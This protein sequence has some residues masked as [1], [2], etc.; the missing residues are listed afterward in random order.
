MLIV[1][2]PEIS[3]VGEAFAEFG[4]LRLLPGRQ[5]DKS[6]VLDAD[7]LLVRSVTPIDQ[8]LLEG[9]RVR[10]VGTATSGV[11]H[12]DLEYLASRGTAF[13]SAP[14]CN[15][16]A[17]ADYVTSAVLAWSQERG[18]SLKGL[19]AGVIGC[20]RIGSRVIRRLGALG[21]E[22]IENDPPLQEQS[23]ASRYRA[24][25]ETLKADIV[26]L[27]VPLTCGARHPT[28][29]LLRA[30]QLERMKPDGLLINTARGG[31][32]DEQALIRCLRR[33]PKRAAV[34]DCWEREPYIDP[35]VLGRVRWG[36]PHIAGYTQEAK[37]R[38]TQMLYQALCVHLNVRAH[39]G[40]W[41]SGNRRSPPIEIADDWDDEQAL[42]GAVFSCYDVRADALALRALAKRAPA[43]RAQ[44]FDALREEYRPRHEFSVSRVNLQKEKTALAAV[45]S[46][47]DFQVHYRGKQAVE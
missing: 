23:G 44:A 11:D 21:L 38:A 28:W 42:R 41:T 19:S 3:H 29:R 43:V 16:G 36:T 17:V 33:H 31:V 25:A 5:W 10:F 35:E 27:H 13:A 47:L 12:V 40:S 9:S 4:E 37:R 45:L 14:G 18:V 6:A 32:V 1:A 39:D 34:I 30:E 15:A 2:D 22:C 26:S 46:A 7:V 20:G 8:A 24:L